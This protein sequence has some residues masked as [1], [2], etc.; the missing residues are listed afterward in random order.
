M[1]YQALEADFKGQLRENMVME[2][3][4]R[5]AGRSSRPAANPVQSTTQDAVQK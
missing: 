5:K 2:Q 1:L 3:A 4:V